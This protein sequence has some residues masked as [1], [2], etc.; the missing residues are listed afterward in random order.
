MRFPVSSTSKADNKIYGGENG[1]KRILEAKQLLWL[2]FVIKLFELLEQPFQPW[3]WPQCTNETVSTCGQV[4]DQFSC[5]HVPK[6]SLPPLIKVH[7]AGIVQPRTNQLHSTLRWVT[8]ESCAVCTLL[9]SSR[10]WICHQDNTVYT[11]NQEA[12]QMTE[13]QKPAVKEF[14]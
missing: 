11:L 9:A 12:T 14:K 7:A 1:S 6:M 10:L 13:A 2:L 8:K 3:F 5:C 4:N